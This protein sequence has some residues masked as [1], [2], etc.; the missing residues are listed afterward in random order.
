MCMLSNK[1]RGSED[2]YS[3]RAEN[4]QHNSLVSIALVT[5]T[6]WKYLIYGIFEVL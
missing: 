5:G 6:S 4:L 2:I 3:E 1:A